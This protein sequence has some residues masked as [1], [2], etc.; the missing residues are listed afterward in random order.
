MLLIYCDDPLRPRQPDSAYVEE[1][2]AA[3]AVGLAYRLISYEALVDDSD[4]ETA[5]RRIPE[6]S[7][8]IPAIYRGWMLRPEQY[9]RLY[10]ALVA[11]GVLL[12]NDP[13]AYRHCHY[14]PEWYP[15][16]EGETPRSVWLHGGNAPSMD[17][18]QRALQPFGARPIIV[19]DFVKSRKHEWDSACYIPSAADG[20]AVRRVVRR[21][22]ELQ[23]DDLNEGLVFREF[24]S[25]E[26]LATHAKSGMPLTKE[27]RI[28]F[29][30]GAP[31]LTAEYWET[32]DYGNVAPTL[33]RY[34]ELA[35]RVRSR[36]FTMD[37]AR[38]TNGA[39]TVIEL[40]DGQVAGLPERADVLAFYRALKQGIEG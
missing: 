9:V 36:F 27:W 13:A 38:Q 24:V 20:E 4:A 25:L 10:D 14:L 32:G 2:A 18:I 21:F 16:F 28:F 35:Q 8:L 40:G 1:V 12:I 30:D 7:P 23:G 34:V 26:P 39:W 11:R 29:L 6:Q 15:L 17:E 37:I 3:E 5:V 22:L 33:A 31:I 19:K